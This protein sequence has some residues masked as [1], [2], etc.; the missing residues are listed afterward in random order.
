MKEPSRFSIVAPRGH[1]K[2]LQ[3][4]Q[5]VAEA[6][7]ENPNL[8]IKVVSA[9][10]PKDKALSF[11]KGHPF[12]SKAASIVMETL[13]EAITKVIDSQQSFNLSMTALKA[14]AD[15][16]CK[17][18]WPTP[19]YKSWNREYSGYPLTGIADQPTAQ[20]CQHPKTYATD[21]MIKSFEQEL[22]AA[23]N[24]DML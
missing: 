22:K 19:D 13:T 12:N 23:R 5:K 3:A 2:T 20:V 1:S 6:L 14:Q 21:E 11:I 18:S 17:N 7:D 8:R 10:T 4:N 9:A 15:L 24:A 16:L